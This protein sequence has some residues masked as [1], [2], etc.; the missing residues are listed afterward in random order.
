MPSRFADM[1]KED[2]EYCSGGIGAAAICYIFGGIFGAVA[3]GIGIWAAISDNK[4]LWYSCATL[5]ITAAVLLVTGGIISC[6]GPKVVK[7]Y[8]FEHYQGKERMISVPAGSEMH[9]T[10]DGNLYVKA[11]W[12]ITFGKTD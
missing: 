4:G 10:Y 2:M 6:V 12:G 7:P 3:V 11:P 5:G 8:T 9:P 1:N